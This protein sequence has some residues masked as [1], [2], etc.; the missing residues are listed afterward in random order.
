MFFRNMEKDVKEEFL[1][2]A[3]AVT[4]GTEQP[5]IALR[6]MGIDVKEE[7]LPEVAAVTQGTEQPS[8]ST[9]ESEMKARDT[10]DSVTCK[11]L[12]IEWQTV[13]CDANADSVSLIYTNNTEAKENLR[14]QLKPIWE[15]LR[16]L[17]EFQQTLHQ[18]AEHIKVAKM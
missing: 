10:C 4:Q 3:A 18:T 11:N 1:P 16:I 9:E 8:I 17:Q 5:Y 7:P 15:K 12:K 2:E 6:Y 14:T 13:A